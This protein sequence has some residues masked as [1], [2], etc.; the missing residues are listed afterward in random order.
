METITVDDKHWLGGAPE[1][2]LKTSQ[3]VV[4]TTLADVTVL[5]SCETPVETEFVVNVDVE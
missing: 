5:I 1:L 3:R 2:V 4:V